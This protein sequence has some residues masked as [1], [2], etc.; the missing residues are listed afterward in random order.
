VQDY[1]LTDFTSEQLAATTAPPS[2]SQ[3]ESWPCAAAVQKVLDEGVVV[4]EWLT[5]CSELTTGY[6]A[7]GAQT[8]KTSL[9]RNIVDVTLM[10]W[11]SSVVWVTG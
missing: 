1:T 2:P 5:V 8:A 9:Q 6:A 11:M 3:A 7:R 10:M 4:R